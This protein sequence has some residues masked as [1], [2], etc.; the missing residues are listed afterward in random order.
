MQ[1]EDMTVSAVEGLVDIEHRLHVVAARGEVGQRVEWG[2]RSIRAH[3]NR[4]AGLP[5]I[6][7]FAEDLLSRQSIGLPET[8]AR[9]A[10]VSIPQR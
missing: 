1:F 10:F 6:D 2:A 4:I 5:A 3:L 8:G 7:V 9:L